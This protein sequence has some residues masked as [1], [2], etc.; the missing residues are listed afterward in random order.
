M[1]A[2]LSG[3]L[4]LLLSNEP[5]SNANAV[6]ATDKRS[7]PTI[8]ETT[9]RPA[10]NCLLISI[11]VP[12]AF[13]RAKTIYSRYQVLTGTKSRILPNTGCRGHPCPRK[14]ETHGG[15]QIKIK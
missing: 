3:S 12:N 6:A 4:G 15:F 7:A 9:E 13:K 2:N 5:I 8:T 10:R 11:R 14:F 1:T